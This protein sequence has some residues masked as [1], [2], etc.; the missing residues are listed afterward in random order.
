MENKDKKYPHYSKKTIR[1][2]YTNKRNGKRYIRRYVV[3]YSRPLGENPPSRPRSR[4]RPRYRYIEL[5]ES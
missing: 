4:P 3:S 5:D 1:V 2:V